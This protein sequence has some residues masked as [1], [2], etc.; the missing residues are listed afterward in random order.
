MEEQKSL[1][2]WYTDTHLDKVNPFTKWRFLSRLKKENPK[3]IFLTG[4]ISNGLMT[5]LDLKMLAYYVKCP[6]YFIL[7]NHDYHL[8]S[9]EETH[10]K[11]ENV[12]SNHNNLIWMTAQKNPVPLNEEVCLIGT[13]GWYDAQLG[14]PNYLKYTTDWILIEDFRL[15]PTMSARIELFREM[16]QH[17]VR[18]MKEK[19]E[20]ALEQNFKTIYLLTHFPPWKEATRDVGTLLEKFWLP[21]NVNLTM[22]RSIETVMKNK[23]KRNVIVLA[24][25]THSDSWIHVSHNIECKVNSAKYYGFLRN[26]ERLFI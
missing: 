13:E 2:M 11:I 6:I 7:G 15:L 18:I 26:E 9:I 20:L 22:G 5:S 24:G 25:H 14:N 21:Y 12:C 23:S 19:L 8:S 17:S 10:S 16:A 4:D 3:G 1:Y